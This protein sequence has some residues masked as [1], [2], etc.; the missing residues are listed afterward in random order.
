MY[1]FSKW[2]EISYGL[3]IFYKRWTLLWSSIFL[4]HIKPSQLFT[5]V[6]W[7]SNK[8]AITSCSCDRGP[9]IL[10]ANSR[11]RTDL[12]LLSLVNICSSAWSL[13][14]RVAAVT[15]VNSGKAAGHLCIT[16]RRI[17]TKNHTSWGLMY[18]KCLSLFKNYQLFYPFSIRILLKYSLVIADLCITL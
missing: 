4:G 10:K 7:K 18:L 15:I 11:G 8:G 3:N 16:K 6:A 9:L 14:L 12:K 1:M 2:V 17:V 13:N 5:F